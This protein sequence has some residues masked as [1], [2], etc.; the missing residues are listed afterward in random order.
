MSKESRATIRSHLIEKD[1]RWKAVFK[2]LKNARR[3]GLIGKSLNN[4]F[5]VLADKF[6]VKR[7]REGGDDATRETNDEDLP[8]DMLLEIFWNMPWQQV[9]ESRQLGKKIARIIDVFVIPRIEV[10]TARSQQ[11]LDLLTKLNRL[12]YR[13]V[14]LGVKDISII[15]PYSSGGYPN[16]DGRD[17]MIEVLVGNTSKTLEKLE[18]Q[19]PTGFTGERLMDAKKLTSLTLR[20]WTILLSESNQ[21]KEISNVVNN[22]LV[23]FGTTFTMIAMD[24]EDTM[25][26]PL[27]QK[28]WSIFP[29]GKPNPVLKPSRRKDS[30]D[31]GYRAKVYLDAPSE[32]YIPFGGS[33]RHLTVFS[34]LYLEQVKKLFENP[35]NNPMSNTRFSFKDQ[36]PVLESIVFDGP[37]RKGEHL[38][39]RYNAFPETLRVVSFAGVD[40]YRTD[41]PARFRQTERESLQRV[42]IYNSTLDETVE[43][44]T[45]I[46]LEAVT[47]AQ[48]NGQIAEIFFEPTKIFYFPP[49]FKI[50]EAMSPSDYPRYSTLSSSVYI[51]P[52]PMAAMKSVPNMFDTEK[53]FRDIAISEEISRMN[54]YRLP[55]KLS[56]YDVIDFSDDDVTTS[57]F[58]MFTFY[59]TVKF[60]CF[61]DLNYYYTDV[62]LKLER[63]A[64][65]FDYTGFDGKLYL[66]NSSNLMQVIVG[67]SFRV[68]EIVLLEGIRD[69]KPEWFDRIYM[70]ETM[71]SLYP[72][73]KEELL[74]IPGVDLMPEETILNG[75][76]I[77]DL[78]DRMELDQ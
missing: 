20:P 70:K 28:K 59:P 11:D 10:L 32:F 39:N 47:R 73:P 66:V 17:D 14:K 2:L 21:L 1:T 18:L 40:T 13:G 29:Y 67:A 37:E 23:E 51:G 16:V 19:I 4:H 54:P 42:C 25:K 49:V 5:F 74:S 38:L 55:V 41:W 57:L 15:Y 12:V 62:S 72:I 77:K 9:M 71:V 27:G 8:E 50:Y 75:T 36:F 65:A 68:R 63:V 64:D 7:G 44:P 35:S 76:S 48:N 46:F 69:R 52:I 53:V 33:V 45:R 34:T 30:S 6:A 31:V 22:Q 43:A 58:T 60:L 3:N 24:E 61:W 26:L 56:A 78:Y